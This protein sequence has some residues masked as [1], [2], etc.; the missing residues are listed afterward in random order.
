MPRGRTGAEII[1][2]LVT[3]KKPVPVEKQFYNPLEAKVG[4]HGRFVN[5]MVTIR[6]E[7]DV[8]LSGELFTVTAIWSWVVESN[9]NKH[10][11]ADYILES[12]DKRLVV[13]VAPTTH[14]GKQGA[15]EVLVL[16]HHWPD[17]QYDQPHV[18]DDESPM[19]IEC[20]N[21]Q[22]PEFI[23]FEG[24]PQEERYFRD[25][26]N[27]VGQVNVIS[28]LN[29]DGV[30]EIEEVVQHD[31]S[32]WTY[33]RDTKDAVDQLY[34]QHLHVQLSGLFNDRS[35]TVVGGDKSLL[36]LRGESIPP[37]NLILY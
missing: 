34:T 18:W 35:G 14:R 26:R 9:G 17:S 5:T 24:T 21:D 33:R 1:K 11:L 20:L 10:N 7:A 29:Q 32:L 4:S 3:G 23:R 16:A 6:G 8:D 30:V 15:P 2:S 31:F 28:D 25:G 19:V 13:R 22:K 37:A 12:G 36:M 27:L